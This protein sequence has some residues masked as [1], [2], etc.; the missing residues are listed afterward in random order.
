MSGV[1]EM[2]W[3]HI[4]LSVVVV[5]SLIMFL[6]GNREEASRMGAAA[7][8]QMAPTWQ[9]IIS[10]LMT[11]VMIVSVIGGLLDS[12]ECDDNT[13]CDYYGLH[14]HRTDRWM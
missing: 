7:V 8:W 14:C 5:I 11:A 2:R 12:E 4:S 9:N 10:L 6:T 1:T 3:Y 13:D